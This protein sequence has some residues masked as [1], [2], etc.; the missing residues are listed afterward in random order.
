VAIMVFINGKPKKK[1]NQTAAL[2]V[3][4][5]A[6]ATPA[7]APF[8]LYP[9]A[10]AIFSFSRLQCTSFRGCV[11]AMC[12]RSY[13]LPLGPSYRTISYRWSGLSLSWSALT[14]TGHA[15]EED[16][17]SVYF[18]RRGLALHILASEANKNQ[19]KK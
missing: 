16:G 15:H 9:L 3:C 8:T 18:L 10:F 12:A 7:L 17:D 5:G 11:R 13:I 19:P 1:P 6:L 14:K 4:N 2:V